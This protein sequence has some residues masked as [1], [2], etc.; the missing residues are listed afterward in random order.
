VSG[1]YFVAIDHLEIGVAL[2]IQYVG[3]LLVL[4]WLRVVHGRRLPRVVWAAVAVS[5][6]GC[7][8][9]VRAYEP[10][11]LSVLGVA[12]AA[13]AAVTFAFY[14]VA[15][16]RA[17]HR[18]QPATTLAWGFGFATLF[19]AVVLPWWSFPFGHFHSLRNVALGLGI[20]IEGTLI[21]FV[22]MIEAVRHIPASRAAIVAT[23]EPVLATIV[24]YFVHDEALAPVQIAGGLLVVGAVIWVQ[25]RA[26]SLAAEAAPAYRARAAA[27]AAPA[28]GSDP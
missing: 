11:G 17:G 3:P 13:G 2:A 23:L 26:G 1:T 15:G 25:W 27:T 28:A 9:V 10:G 14:L 5:L 7:A 12:A 6:V 22:L 18:Y 21:P 19:W 20:G 16:E 8:L 4:L 24:A